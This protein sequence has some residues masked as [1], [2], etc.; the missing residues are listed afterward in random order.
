LRIR[1]KQRKVS[2]ET[3][4]TGLIGWPVAHSLS[5]AIHNGAFEK[6]SLPWRY[7]LYPVEPGNF[8]N[9]I[10]KLMD[11][12]R[13]F[14][15]TF[16]YK[17]KISAY[18]DDVSPGASSI[19]AVNCAKNDN[20]R[21]TGTNT[22]SSGFLKAL[23]EDINPHDRNIFIL[24]AGGAAKAA[25]F[26]LAES[27]TRKIFIK[28]PDAEKARDLIKRLNRFAPAQA[29]FISDD[30]T[31]LK[32]CDV[33]VNATPLGMADERIPLPADILHKGLYVFE[34]IYNRETPLLKAAAERGLRR[35]DGLNMLVYQAADSF[36]FWTGEKAPV[37][38]MK[39][40]VK[41]DL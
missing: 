9:G 13:G 30:F 41:K 18:L 28:D 17:E 8:D 34:C 14:N 31:E 36:T 12:L 21:W 10:K 6:L 5:P 23:K 25:A 16:P 37:E 27:G 22:D 32:N 29:V 26:S 1:G 35:Q 19:G 2:K 33:L 4:K 15:I 38:L 11:E 40:R 3:M 7:G 24:G 39:D 20:G